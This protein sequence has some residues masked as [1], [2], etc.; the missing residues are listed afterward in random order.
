[1]L[2]F[3]GRSKAIHGPKHQT[4]FLQLLAIAATLV[5]V[6]RSDGTGILGAGKWLYK[7]VCAHSCRVVLRDSHLLCEAGNAVTKRQH[8]P[9]SD[10]SPECWLLDAAFLRTMALC[11]DEYCA[12]DR[13]PLSVIEEYWEGHLAT[14]SIGDWSQ[15]M[16]PIMSYQEALRF[17]NDDVDDL[18]AENVPIVVLG[19]PLNETSFVAEDDFIPTK[20]YQTAFQWGEFD[21]GVN[22][23][24]SPLIFEDAKTNTA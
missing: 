2:S 6:V 7:P 15:E 13:I 1:M 10:S 23:Y 18:G 3:V 4:T 20:N 24:C 9:A 12:R 8:H 22:R 16:R 17:A 5:C 14:G 19:E 11:I 21:H